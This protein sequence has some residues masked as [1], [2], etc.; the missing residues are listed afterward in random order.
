MNITST[1]IVISF[2][3]TSVINVAFSLA[4]ELPAVALL[5]SIS[6]GLLSL[7]ILITAFIRTSLQ[8]V[9][10][11]YQKTAQ[12]VRYPEHRMPYFLVALFVTLFVVG[13]YCLN[14]WLDGQLP[15]ISGTV[16]AAMICISTIIV[17]VVFEKLNTL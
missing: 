10:R 13:I 5:A 7:T 12:A 17:L 2:L 6:T 8:A 11:P 4:T 15:T 1:D 9:Q 3:I 14:H 16:E